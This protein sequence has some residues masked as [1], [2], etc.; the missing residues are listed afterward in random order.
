MNNFNVNV[1]G[2]MLQFNH[3]RLVFRNFSGE[4]SKYNREGDRNF[5]VV[6]PDVDTAQDLIDL[7]WNV[8]IKPPRE[9]GDDPFCYLAVKIKF[10]GRGPVVKLRS[11]LNSN[12]LDENTVGLLD[13]IDIMDASVDVRPYDWEMNGNTGRSAY[14]D[15]IE[16]VQ[17]KSRFDEDEWP[18]E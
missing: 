3:V 18:E 13:K 8:R 15:G 12:K 6:I 17:A 10:N 7:G 5:A 11:G 4:G 16:V 9:E 2:N 1:V 14:L